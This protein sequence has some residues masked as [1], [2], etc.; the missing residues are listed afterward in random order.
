MKVSE[1]LKIIN[2]A[3]EK[4]GPDFLEKD[5]FIPT[6]KKF[7]GELTSPCVEESGFCDF[8]VNENL[9]LRESSLLLAHHGYSHFDKTV[10]RQETEN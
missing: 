6:S 8:C 9:N 3:V 5:V 10:Q 7:N 2:D 4:N 1:L